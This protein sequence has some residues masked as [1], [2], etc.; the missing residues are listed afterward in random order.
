MSP[1]KGQARR[2]FLKDAIVGA[3]SVPAMSLF[4]S[5][6]CSSSEK[7]ELD[8]VTIPDPDGWHPSLR[9]KGDWLIVKISDGV[10]SCYGRHRTARTMR[11]VAKQPGQYLRNEFPVFLC[12]L[13]P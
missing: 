13:N 11:P 4:P 12:P 9:L 3:L 8:F 1:G 6:G 10:L 2:R 5:I 7:L